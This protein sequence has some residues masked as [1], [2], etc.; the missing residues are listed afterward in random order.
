MRMSPT[1]LWATGVLLRLFA[2]LPHARMKEMYGC[3]SNQQGSVG[4]R[5]RFPQSGHCRCRVTQDLMVYRE[6]SILWMNP[7]PISNLSVLHIAQTDGWLRTCFSATAASCLDRETGMPS[8][9]VSYPISTFTRLTARWIPSSK[10]TDRF[11]R[12]R[13]NRSRG[14]SRLCVNLTIAEFLR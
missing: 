12:V 11:I 5:L 3:S 1:F 6:R 13:W 4:W 7:D 8:T 9:T 10:S 14:E 2:M